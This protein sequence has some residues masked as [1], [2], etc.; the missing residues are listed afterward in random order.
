MILISEVLSNIPLIQLFI[1][2]DWSEIHDMIKYKIFSISLIYFPLR[3]DNTLKPI[4]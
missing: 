4:E 3:H 2:L 1:W